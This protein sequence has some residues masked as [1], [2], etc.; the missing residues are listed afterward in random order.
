MLL[1][2]Y[3]SLY[4][5]S[6]GN[7][8]KN[9]RVLMEYI[10][11]AKAEKTRT[12][13]LADQMEA[14]RVKNKVRYNRSSDRSES[15]YLQLRLGCPRASRCPCCREAVGNPRRRARCCRQGVNTPYT[16]IQ[17]SFCPRPHDFSLA[18]SGPLTVRSLLSQ[19]PPRTVIVSYAT[20][21]L[22]IIQQV[23]HA[24]MLPYC[25]LDIVSWYEFSLVFH[26]VYAYLSVRRD[27]TLHDQV[28]PHPRPRRL[29]NRPPSGTPRSE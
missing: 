5:K 24:C 4:Q 15:V 1:R 7:V 12:K 21:A 22:S 14:R 26:L 25:K 19:I 9:K 16:F 20:H 17:T 3:H 29:E 6:K 23:A 8:F 13:V 28:H 11:K 27:V 18:L 2:R 10:H